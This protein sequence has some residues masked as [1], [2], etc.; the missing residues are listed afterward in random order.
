METR[1][2]TTNISIDVMSCRLTHLGIR[3]EK[4][5]H[6]ARYPNYLLKSA[7]LYHSYV[8]K[9]STNRVQHGTFMSPPTTPTYVLNDAS[10]YTAVL[11][12]PIQIYLTII[13]DIT[14]LQHTTVLSSLLRLLRRL[15]NI[16]FPICATSLPNTLQGKRTKNSLRQNFYM[17]SP[18]SR[19]SITACA[20][21][22]M[23]TSMLLT[24][25]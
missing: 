20:V 12:H 13:T 1:H 16:P 10:H 22:V 6:F 7:V 14:D 21:F 11:Q 4:P 18:Q 9:I 17:H 8:A 23:E 19:I 2:P 15:R 3:H 25:P 5:P 24:R